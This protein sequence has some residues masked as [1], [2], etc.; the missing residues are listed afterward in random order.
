MIFTGKVLEDSLLHPG[1]LKTSGMDAVIALSEENARFAGML[2]YTGRLA[3]GMAADFAVFDEDPLSA[4]TAEA[5]NALRAS[6]TVLAGKIVYDAAKDSP[7]ALSA[8]F[9]EQLGL[10]AEE[11]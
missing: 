5:F 7:Q 8:R 9:T 10:I 11:L 3:E 1:Q 4:K 2:G 6:K